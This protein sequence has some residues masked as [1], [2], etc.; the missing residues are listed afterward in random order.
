M[1]KLR[2]R[3]RDAPGAEWREVAVPKS[4]RAL[5]LLNL[6]AGGCCAV[7]VGWGA[8][9]RAALLRPRAAVWRVLQAP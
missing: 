5:V 2:L 6:Q 8:V 9:G 7:D 1:N 4:V 3:V